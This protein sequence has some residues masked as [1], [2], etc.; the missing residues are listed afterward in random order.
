MDIDDGESLSAFGTFNDLP[1]SQGKVALEDADITSRAATMPGLRACTE[2]LHF[3]FS[4][5]V[6]GILTEGASLQMYPVMAW[7]APQ[8]YLAFFMHKNYE[9]LDG[10]GETTEISALALDRS[11]RPIRLLPAVSSWYE[12]E[13]SI[14]IRDFVYSSHQFMTTEE[15]FDPLERD[16]LGNVL[17]YKED[18]RSGA[19]AVH[20][21]NWAPASK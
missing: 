5:L 1:P 18:A 2:N 13:G 7:R 14:R 20:E 21:I 3:S 10:E 6:D 12:Y 11:G 9:T 4:I 17:T 8:G 16:E 15:I 19:S